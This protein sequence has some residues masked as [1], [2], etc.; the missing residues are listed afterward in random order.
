MKVKALIDCVGVE[1]ELKKN[2]T[3]DL[4]KALAE[5]LLKFQYVEE[6]KTVKKSPKKKV[7]E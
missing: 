4:S 5:K 6:V 7:N 2:E 1:Y 3:A